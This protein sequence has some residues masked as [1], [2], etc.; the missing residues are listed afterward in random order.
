M[1]IGIFNTSKN[2][3]PSKGSI[4]SSGY[5]LAANEDVTLQPGEMKMIRTG[6]FL[7]LPY[8]YEAQIRPRSGL[9]LKESLITHFGTIDSD[10]RGEIGIIMQNASSSVKHIKT[11]M[12]VAQMVFAEVP[13][14]QFYTMTQEMFDAEKDTDRGEGGF[15]STGTL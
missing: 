14:T 12:R 7:V 11:G 13:F 10:Y 6:I 3:L 5:D 15:G 9:T 4:G 1:Q 2:P 8:Q